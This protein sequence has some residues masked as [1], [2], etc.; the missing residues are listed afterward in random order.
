MRELCCYTPGLG[1]PNVIF[2]N[3][4]LFLEHEILGHLGFLQGFS[5]HFRVANENI[6][7]SWQ[8]AMFTKCDSKVASVIRLDSISFTTNSKLIFL[9][10][11]FFKKAILKHNCKTFIVFP[12]FVLTPEYK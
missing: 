11:T 1:F 2:I 12:H 3:L 10:G 8:D 4:T 9:Q 7:H 5:K 6:W